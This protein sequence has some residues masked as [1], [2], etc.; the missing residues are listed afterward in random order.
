MSD[1]PANCNDALGRLFATLSRSLLQ[2]LDEAEPW[3]EA[4][5]VAAR[6]SLKQVAA[7]QRRSIARL[8]DLVVRRHVLPESASFP[9]GFAALHYLAL[10]FLM[11]RLIADQ[12]GVVAA[13][14]E[15]L[16]ACRDD[17]ATRVL[18]RVQTREAEHFDRLRQI[19]RSLGPA[20]NSGREIA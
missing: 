2:Y 1:P 20:E 14:D 13:I 10:D 11:D 17:Q 12:I 3:T 6:E 19:A 8:A 15:A 5:Q 9:S 18:E 7:S 16:A 4:R